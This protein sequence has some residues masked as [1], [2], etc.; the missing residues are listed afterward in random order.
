MAKGYWMVGTDVIDPVAYIPFT[1]ADGPA[2]AAYGGRFLVQGGDFDHLEGI[3]RHR[4]VVLEFPSFDQ[5]LACYRSPQYQAALALRRSYAIVDLA[6]LEGYEGPEPSPAP[7]PETTPGHPRGY[8]LVR[9]DITDPERYKDYLAANGEAFAAFGGWFLVRGVLGPDRLVVTPGVRPAGVAVGD[10]KRFATP[11]DAFRAGA[12]AVVV[13]RPII[14]A[15]DPVEAARAIL[16][17]IARS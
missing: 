15:D 5:A 12:D 16:A 10:Q 8:W 9:V 6:V 17:E 3:Q 7:P 11:S 14:E 4:N 2:Y 13:G 1:E